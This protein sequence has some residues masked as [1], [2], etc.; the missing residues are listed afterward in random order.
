[1][2]S[3]YLFCSWRWR[4]HYLQTIGNIAHIHTVQKLNSEPQWWPEISNISPLFSLSLLFLNFSEVNAETKYQ[5]WLR[6]CY[7]DT[8]MRLL[9]VMSRHKPS[10]QLQ[11]LSTMMKLIS[12]EG[13]YPIDYRGKEEYYFP[14][15]KLRVSIL[16]TYHLYICEKKLIS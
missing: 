13:K 14:V 3:A 6:E 10:M 11:A 15:Q 16:Q 4:Q 1:M 8:F 12:L 5:V 9:S 7:E 2:A